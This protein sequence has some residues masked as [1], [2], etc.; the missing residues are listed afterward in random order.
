[1]YQVGS[2]CRVE[3]SCWSHIGLTTF[4][5]CPGQ[6]LWTWHWRRWWTGGGLP[7]WEEDAAAAEIEDKSIF[8]ILDA[9]FFNKKPLESWNFGPRNHQQTPIMAVSDCW[10]CKMIK[11]VGE[12]KIGDAP[13]VGESSQ[14]HQ[15]RW[16][17]WRCPSLSVGGWI[18]WWRGTLWQGQLVG[19]FGELGSW[20]GEGLCVDLCGCVFIVPVPQ[21]LFGLYINYKYQ[22]VV[23]FVSEWWNWWRVKIR[24]ERSMGLAGLE[25]LVGCFFLQLGVW[26]GG[27]GGLHA[28][29]DHSMSGKV[30]TWQQEQTE[31]FELWPP[32]N[33]TNKKAR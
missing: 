2:C 16:F 8:L 20:G 12:Q 13:E 30:S 29:E 9:F 1:M 21:N 4:Y 23:G 6:G 18:L 24:R 27:K 11:A 32:Q 5:V 14:R 26:E 33:N 31:V 28:S 7:Q 3:T 22:E 15:P 17:L 25:L 19:F 10:G